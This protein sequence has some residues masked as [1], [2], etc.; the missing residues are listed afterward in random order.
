MISYLQKPLNLILS[1][2]SWISSLMSSEWTTVRGMPVSVSTE[3]TNFCNLKCPECSSG[4]DQMTRQRGY[5]DIV[6]YRKAIDE[7][8]P[9][10]YNVNLYFQGEPMMHPLFFSFVDYCK[11]IHSTVSTNGHFLSPENS[12]KIANSGLNRLIVSLDGT[13]QDCYSKYRIGGN[14]DMVMDGLRTVSEYRKLNNSKLKIE[15][16]FLVNRFNQHQISEVRAIAKRTGASLK[17]K[18][19]QIIN[20]EKTGYWLPDSRKF[21]RYEEIGDDYFIK[22]DLPDRCARLWFNPVITWDGKVIPCCFDKDT[23]HIMGDLNIDSFRDIWN[24]PR[25]R[26]FRRAI[27]QNRSMINI[28]RN[29]TEGL[30]EAKY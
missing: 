6:L 27:L 5:M 24:G 25:Y 26:V 16:Q 8:R 20:G 28:C 23:E 21:R 11:G 4:S 29:C 15:I 2:S 30:R 10:L 7:L 13:D 1:G 9:F 14:F 19:M 22:S 3:L 17:L 12:E 18:S